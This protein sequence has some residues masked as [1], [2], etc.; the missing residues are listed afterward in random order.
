MKTS[1]PSATRQEKRRFIIMA[2][3]VGCINHLGTPAETHHLI[4]ETTGN[5]IS[6]LASIPLCSNCHLDIHKKKHSFR[7]HYGTDAQLLSRTNREVKRFED[8]TI[9]AAQ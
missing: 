3:E 9:G 1:L 4:S 6:H 5:R 8:N 7:K 2:Q